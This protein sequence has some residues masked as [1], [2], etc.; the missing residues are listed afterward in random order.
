MGN[1][2][3]AFLSGRSQRSVAVPSVS[4]DVV[5]SLSGVFQARFLQESKELDVFGTKNAKFS[6]GNSHE[7][8]RGTGVRG[9]GDRS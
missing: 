5:G 2:G 3:D 1:E 8:E 7:T 9:R 4:G 6:S